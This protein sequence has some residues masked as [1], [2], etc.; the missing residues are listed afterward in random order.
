MPAVSMI[1]NPRPLLPTGTYVAVPCRVLEPLPSLG[2]KLRV[3]PPPAPPP[4]SLVAPVGFVAES[5][6]NCGVGMKRTSPLPVTSTVWPGPVMSVCA[7]PCCGG[8]PGPLKS[9]KVTAWLP[10]MV[11]FTVMSQP[12]PDASTLSGSQSA[13]VPAKSTFPDPR[14]PTVA[15][16][17]FITKR[18]RLRAAMRPVK[19]RKVPRSRFSSP[20]WSESARSAYCSIWNCVLGLSEIFAW[21]TM[22][23]C[24]MPRVPVTIA[25]PASTGVPR[26]TATRC[27]PLFCTLTSP[28]TKVKVPLCPKTGPAPT[29]PPSTRRQW[30]FL[31]WCMAMPP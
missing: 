29:R 15:T 4:V 8:S 26:V 31:G 21:S 23:S 7:P 20:P 6:M 30:S 25:S 1:V 10:S 13:A 18:S 27:P 22:V 3:A 2:P 9:P 16:F 12:A 17:V 24:A 19:V 11:W 14:M 5:A 28:V